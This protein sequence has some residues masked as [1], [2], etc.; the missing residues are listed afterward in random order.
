[1]ARSPSARSPK[2]AERAR[3]QFEAAMNVVGGNPLFAPLRRGAVSVYREDLGR[4]AWALVGSAGVL[5]CDTR[6]APV[7]EWSWVLAHQLCHLGM[8]HLREGRR[9]ERDGRIDPSWNAACCVEV[10]RLLAHLKIGRCPLILPELPDGDLESMWRRWR[11]SGETP[12]ADPGLY[13]VANNGDLVTGARLGATYGLAPQWGRAGPPDWEG[14]FA[15]GLQAAVRSAVEVAG[16]ERDHLT[17]ASGGHKTEWQRA[18]EWFVSSYPLLGGVAAGIRLVEDVDKCRIYNI[19]IAAVDAL[20]GEIVVHPQ[21]GLQPLEKRFVI[22]HEIL[23]AALRHDTRTGGRDPWLWNVAA[24]LVIN[25]WLV[26]MGVG[27][28]PE[29]GLYDPALRGWSAEE[30]YERIVS[31]LR[32]YRKAATFAGIGACDVLDGRLGSRNVDLDEFYRRALANGLDYHTTSGRGL[33]PAGLIE[34]IRARTHPPIGWQVELARWFDD[35]LP[36]AERRR[37]YARLSRRQA[38]TPDIPRPALV[39]PEEWER[40]RTFGVV[41]DT[42]GSMGAE[43]LGAALGAIASYCAARDVSGARV[44]FC[45]A[46]AYDAGWMAPE[47]IAGRVKVRGRGG[48][49]LQPGVDLLER[50]DDFPPKGPILVITDTDC[51]HIR[52]RREHAYLVPRGRRLPFTPKGPVFKMQL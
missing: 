48:T 40:S 43:L 29:G 17:G 2:A 13:G 16:G 15:Q 51:D 45:D 7:D 36:A 47:D 4:D 27:E 25:G 35:W 3:K 34:E 44:V 21:S 26:E 42:S 20:A 5:V 19:R 39:R 28:L 37:T 18:L 33:V 22:A 8:G 46:V 30:V 1:M 11:D 10:D 14:L 31:D 6:L 23:H 52:V 32:R 41:V 50:A 49:V 9:I 24:D 12:V 38:A